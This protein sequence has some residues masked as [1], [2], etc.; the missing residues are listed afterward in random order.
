[1]KVVS[2]VALLLSAGLFVNGAIRANAAADA[3]V[4]ID[5]DASFWNRYLQDIESLPSAAPSASPSDATSEPTMEPTPATPEPTPAT[6][7]PTPATPEPTLATPEPT[8]ATPEPT[9]ATPEPTLATPEPTSSPTSTPSAP[10]SFSPTAAPTGVCV[11]ELEMNCNSVD[12]PDVPCTEIPSET[13]LVCT[14]P[15][16]VRELKFIYTAE[17]CSGDTMCVDF[18]TSPTIAQVTLIDAATG[19]T[20]ASVAVTVGDVIVLEDDNCLPPAINATVSTPTGTVT[21]SISMDTSCGAGGRGLVLRESYGAFESVGYS[22]DENDIHNCVE[23]VVYDLEVCNAGQTEEVLYQFDL[24]VNGTVTDL[25]EGVSVDDLMLSPG[26]CFDAVKTELIERCSVTQYIA[27][28]TANATNPD[29]GVP[30]PCED[31]EEITFGF[32]PGTLS[33]TPSPSA[34]PSP[35]PSASPS[36]PLTASPVATPAPVTAE[37]SPA[38]S[39]APSAVPTG[40]CAVELEMNCTTVDLGIPCTEIPSEDQFV[41][42]CPECVR[43]L[44]FVYTGA[45]CSGN[46]A[47]C[48]DFGVNPST[49][50]VVIGDA[51][52]ANQTIYEGIVISDMVIILE[53]AECLPT[54][55]VVTVST[56]VGTTT[57]AFVI[58]SSCGLGGQGLVLAESYGAFEFSGYSCD[59]TDSHNCVLEVVY[60]L[61]VCN[62]GST[63]ETLYEFEFDLNGTITDLI[64]ET[65]EG[66]LALS[67]NECFTAVKNELIERC[68]EREYIAKAQANMTD[69]ATGVPFPCD[70]VEEIMFSFTPVTPPPTT[71]APTTPAPTTPAPTTPAPT[72]PAPT[73]PAPTTL[74][75]VTPAPSSPEPSPAPSPEPTTACIIDVEIDGCFNFTTPLDNSCEGRP[76]VMTFRY[77]GGDCSQSDNL[78]DRQKFDCFDIEPEDGGSG[79]PPLTAGTVSYVVATQLNADDVIYF[80]GFVPVGETFT[81]NDNRTFD[82]LSADMNIT[83]YDP[84]NSSDPATI[85]TAAN[86]QQTT[87]VHLSCSQPLF[88]KDRFG[89]SQV[90]EFIEDDGRTVSC[91][92]ATSIDT[93]TLTLNTTGLSGQTEIRLLEMNIISNTEGFINKTDEVNGVIIS[94][95]EVLTLSPINV[96]LDLT[97]RTR[98]TFFTTVVGETLDGSTECNGFDFHECVA[99]LPLPPLF[100]TLAPTPSPTITAFPTP[101]PETTDCS[102]EALIECVVQDP[103]GPTCEEISAPNATRCSTG[104]VVSLLQFVLTGNAC[105][106]TPDCVDTPSDEGDLSGQVYMEI[107][108]CET[109]AFF[110]GT[111]DN[112]DLITVNS[113]GNFLCDSIEITISTVN[114]NEEEETNSGVLLQSLSVPTS[115]LSEAESATGWSLGTDYGA[116]RLDKYVSDLDGTQ[117]VFATFLMNYVIDN[118]GAFGANIDSASLDSAFSG[119][120]LLLNG[121]TVVAPRSRLSIGT[122]TVTVNLTESS[123]SAFD[124]GLAISDELCD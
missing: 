28:A 87:F 58:D 78:Q 77:N 19:A 22:C 1:M 41:C 121:N 109:T 23:E 44:R 113:R 65:P 8:P 85:I 48:T 62:V 14:C 53:N 21:Q 49:A 43:E 3:S 50:Y 123:G 42:T 63:E 54:S 89:S 36:S 39:P 46:E 103:F 86:M 74:A 52:S 30:T 91:F 40:V 79:P 95:G 100:P 10:P 105:G 115:C 80:E 20:V 33:P 35:A 117:A 82:R 96:T 61:E 11:I 9:P 47:E 13:D 57:Q 70:D 27:K 32:T 68:S 118:P 12:R 119:E 111:A 45:A 112:G 104:A 64:A 5:E 102:A 75:P 94:A 2:S 99:G 98:Y 83:M 31:V 7:E 51:T 120:Q 67:P 55:L 76:I 29:T 15:D 6:P 59:D 34:A 106:S 84:K 92:V 90:V 101:D 18:E 60:D 122:E 114:F 66:D 97:E 69:P 26:D 71:P 124:F 16:C 93:L 116:L 25:L 24:D 107:L 110:Q 37:P 56:A 4:G 108:D 38:P 73:T 17:G 81:L 72:T 88:L